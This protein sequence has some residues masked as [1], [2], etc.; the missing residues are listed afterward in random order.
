MK[1][2]NIIEFLKTYLLTLILII[3]AFICSYSAD[4]GIE[5]KTVSNRVVDDFEK[6]H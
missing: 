3:A 6:Y 4:S 1:K 5:K 2:I